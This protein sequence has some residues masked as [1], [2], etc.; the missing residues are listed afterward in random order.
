MLVLKLEGQSYQYIAKKAKISRQRVQQ[1]L[2]PPKAIRDFVIKKYQAKCVNCGLYVGR[3]GHIHHE[4]ANGEEDYNDIN[5]LQLL[6]IFC[7]HKRHIKKPDKF[8]PQCGKLL[9]VKEHEFCS[10]ECQKKYHTVIRTC[11]YCENKF[12]ITL[13]QF[14]TRKKQNTSG[15]FFC[16]RK[17]YHN[18]R[19]KKS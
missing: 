6:C 1:L 14:H 12:P 9:I 5:N 4:P 3:R 2:S 8:C 17:C 18:S 19:L 16:S 7:H 11:S 13:T 10:R 15:L